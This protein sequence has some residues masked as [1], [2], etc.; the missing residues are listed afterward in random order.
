MS[1]KKAPQKA[2][3]IFHSIMKI[4]VS[5]KRLF[6]LSVDGLVR[7]YQMSRV[8]T[9]VKGVTNFQKPKPKNCN[10]DIFYLT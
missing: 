5:P 4:T 7:L 6:A 3:N 9:S 10:A 8:S 2:S 1:D